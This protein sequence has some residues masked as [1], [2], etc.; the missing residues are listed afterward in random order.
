MMLLG[1]DLFVYRIYKP[2]DLE[3]PAAEIDWYRKNY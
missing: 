1:R 3:A 2:F